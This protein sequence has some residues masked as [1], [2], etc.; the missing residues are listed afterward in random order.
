MSKTGTVRRRASA[1][2]AALLGMLLVVGVATLAVA[3]TDG[4]DTVI[5]ACVKSDT[6][7]NGQ[8]RI[9]SAA[10]SCRSNETAI[11]WNVT[12]PPG[13]AGPA[14]PAGPQGP[15]GPAGSQGPKGDDGPQ[16]PAGPAGPQGD[17]GE[18]GPQGDDG[19]RGPAGPAGPQGDTGPQGP[20][21]P[22]GPQGPAGPGLGGLQ[23]IEQLSELNGDDTKVV[24]AL[25]PEGSQ[26]IGGGASVG[27]PNQVALADSDFYVDLFGNRIGWLARADEVVSANVSWILVAH[28]LCAG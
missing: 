1:G 8:V 17:M 25:C 4:D 21:G 23:V 19:A 22:E 5:R 11:Q 13:P 16:G 26:A 10:E 3:K 27:G 15:A 24:L 9:A 18:Q 2:A 6:P 28:V 20:Q 12:G 14:G 7:G